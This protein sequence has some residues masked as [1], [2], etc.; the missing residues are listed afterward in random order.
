MEK[1]PQTPADTELLRDLAKLIGGQSTPELDVQSPQ[2]DMALL[3]NM[4]RLPQL[5]SQ[6]QAADAMLQKIKLMDVEDVQPYLKQCQ[7]ASSQRQQLIRLALQIIPIEHLVSRASG[8]PSSISAAFI[9]DSIKAMETEISN[10]LRQGRINYKYFIDTY[11]KYHDS[12]EGIRI[13]IYAE[14]VQILEHDLKLISDTLTKLR[15]LVPEY[16]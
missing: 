4:Q 6:Y 3:L 7:A 5:H 14:I 11:A 16:F 1:K 8:E 10:D 13:G 2:K 9:V 15:G 12:F